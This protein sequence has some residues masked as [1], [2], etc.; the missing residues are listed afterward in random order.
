MH[1]G[2]SR[3]LEFKKR[4]NVSKSWFNYQN[5]MSYIGCA[6]S[7]N[8]GDLILTDAAIKL[9]K[10]VNLIPNS[11]L[12]GLAYTRLAPLFDYAGQI[13]LRGPIS[14]N[15]LILGAGTL[16]NDP[17]FHG[18]LLRYHKN[19]MAFSIFGTSVEWGKYTGNRLAELASILKS[20]Q[21]VAVRD[22]YSSAK[23]KEIGVESEI[24]GD[25]ALS[26]V[27]SN[28]PRTLK[29]KLTIGV[30]LCGSRGQV[31]GDSDAIIIAIA[32]FIKELDALGHNVV[33]F[34]MHSN[35]YAD[36]K[37][38]TTLIEHSDSRV[39]WWRENDVN[40]VIEFIEKC[41]VVIG[42][43][44]HAAILAT[45]MSVPT[46]AIAYRPK[47]K[48]YMNSIGMDE[49]TIEPEESSILHDLLLEK[50][51]LLIRNYETISTELKV[52]VEKY[53]EKQ[54]EAAQKIKMSFTK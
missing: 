20:A 30:N 8:L 39:V 24:I 54:H 21:V 32:D 38:L 29:Q 17:F 50:W 14:P 27:E 13:V 44:L 5:R 15:H 45:G 49:Y 1:D 36:I 46:I 40:G 4:V 33:F 11:P 42:Q 19:N 43:R 34:A 53:R 22:S 6:A 7:V 12:S 31:I 25:I 3:L 9:L 41:D 10:D 47:C 52:V 23:L 28:I 2:L 16:L 35:D 18:I 26:L 48:N 51:N 37:Y